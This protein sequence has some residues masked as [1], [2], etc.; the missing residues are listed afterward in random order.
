VFFQRTPQDFVPGVIE[1]IFSTGE[2]DQ[3]KYYF[4]LRRNI[5]LVAE[6]QDPFQLYGD[7]GAEL[8][9][10]THSQHLDIVPVSTSR[11]CHSISMKWGETDVVLKPLNRV[12]S[13]AWFEQS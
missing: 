13:S 8:W 2:E 9:S 4:A 1:Y 10:S 11:I 3:Q 6:H 7:F 5:P 12:S